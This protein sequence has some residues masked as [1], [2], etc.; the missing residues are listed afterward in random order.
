[1]MVRE[2]RTPAKS[3]LDGRRRSRHDGGA[4]NDKSGLPELPEGVEIKPVVGYEGL[5]S[6]T[7]D[8]RVWRHPRTISAGW[9]TK[10][11]VGGCW[12]KPHLRRDGYYTASVGRDGMRTRLPIHKLVAAAFH[13]PRPKGYDIDHVDRDRVNNEAANLRYVTRMVNRLN[14]ACRGYSW[15]PVNQKW[16]AQICVGGQPYFL[17]RFASE[18]E[19][20][21]AYIQV[22]RNLGMLRAQAE[23]GTAITLQGRDIPNTI[24]KTCKV[25]RRSRI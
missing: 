19:A 2:C 20:R 14:N 12:A 21:E 16:K 10:K 8:G 6:V 11:R 18:G 25:T 13:G 4:M 22:K 3:R 9:D 5:Y 17:G 7:S 23:S 1:M 24:A 15:D